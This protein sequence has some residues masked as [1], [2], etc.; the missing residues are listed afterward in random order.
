MENVMTGVGNCFKILFMKGGEKNRLSWRLFYTG[1][2]LVHYGVFLF[3]HAIL[4]GVLFGSIH[5]V[6]EE[7]FAYITDSGGVFFLAIMAF[8]H[9]RASILEVSRLNRRQDTD[10]HPRVG[11]LMVKPYLRVFLMQVM[12]IVLGWPL[13]LLPG[14]IVGGILIVLFKTAA[15]LASHNLVN[16]FGGERLLDKFAEHY[17]ARGY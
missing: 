2:F 9:T 15:D 3:G 1:F 8:S 6:P 17:R 13:T 16:H 10:L 11:Y 12:L 5:S 14:T 7:L 4:L